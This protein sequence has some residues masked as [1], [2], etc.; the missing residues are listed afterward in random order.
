[1][2]IKIEESPYGDKGAVYTGLLGMIQHFRLQLIH[3]RK[4][5]KTK[6]EREYLEQDIKGYEMILDSGSEKNAVNFLD[7]KDQERRGLQK[8]F[9]DNVAVIEFMKANN[10]WEDK[11]GS[12]R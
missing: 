4:Q 11:N 2:E 6:E 3:Y 1:M 9:K 10:L 7:L 8:A 5:D 12:V